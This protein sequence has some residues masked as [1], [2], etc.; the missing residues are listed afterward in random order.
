LAAPNRKYKAWNCYL[1]IHSRLPVD[2]N[3]IVLIKDGKE[4]Y[5][6]LSDKFFLD[7]AVVIM[8]GLGFATVLTLIVAPVLYAIFF[9]IKVKA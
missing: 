2:Y 7:M 9:N 1:V 5:T 3:A 6:L 8:F 4:S